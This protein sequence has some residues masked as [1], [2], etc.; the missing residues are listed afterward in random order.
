MNTFLLTMMLEELLFLELLTAIDPPWPN[1]EV[2][3]AFSS[4]DDD[5]EEEELSEEKRPFFSF[6][7]F[8]SLAEI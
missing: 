7:F 1:F 3:L 4:E 8:F 6:F 2:F 5:D